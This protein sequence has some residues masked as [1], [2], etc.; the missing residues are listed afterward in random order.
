MKVYVEPSYEEMSTLAARLVG[1]Q[2]RLEPNS[3]LGLA[4]GGTPVGMYKELVRMHKE[5][6]LDFSKITTFN[7]DEYYPL[8]RESDQSYYYY[9]TDHLFSHVNINKDQIHIPN[10]E[11]KE[12]ELE[13]INYEKKIQKAG[14][15]DLQVLGIGNNGHIGF[16]EPEESF[17]KRTHLVDLVEDTIQ[18]NSRFFDSIDDVPKQ[19]LSMGIGSIIKAKK[20]VLLANGSHKAKIIAETIYGDVRPQVPSTILQFHPDVTFVLDAEAAA[21]LKKYIK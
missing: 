19:A 2:I 13:C 15:I 8:S 3:V 21:E 17:A 11:A 14:G 1:A 4:T 5:E 9:M 6:G 10:G 12:V 16:N 20:I 7:L 18:A